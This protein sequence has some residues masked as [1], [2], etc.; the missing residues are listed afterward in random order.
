[1]CSS[2]AATG[3]GTGVRIEL[4]AVK[5]FETRRTALLDQ[6]RMKMDMIVATGG[7]A[8]WRRAWAFWT[9]EDCTVG[10]GLSICATEAW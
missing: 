9:P 2:S 10:Y 5:W 8:R 4:K 1:M 6:D 7:Q 3:R